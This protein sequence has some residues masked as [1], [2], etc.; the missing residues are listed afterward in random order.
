MR[1]RCDVTLRLARENPPNSYRYERLENIRSGVARIPD[2]AEVGYE[3]GRES[4]VIQPRKVSAGSRSRMARVEDFIRQFFEEVVNNH[5]G[6]IN[7]EIVEGDI[8]VDY[9]L[10]LGENNREASVDASIASQ[11]IVEIRELLKNNDNPVLT[12]ALGSDVEFSARYKKGHRWSG[13]KTLTEFL[14]AVFEEVKEEDLVVEGGWVWNRKVHRKPK[15]THIPAQPWAE[16]LDGIVLKAMRTA[17]LPRVDRRSWDIVLEAF[18]EYGTAFTAE[19]YNLTQCTSWVRDRLAEQGVHVG[20]QI[21][22]DTFH[23]TKNGAGGYEK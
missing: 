8:D 20:R 9:G 13:Y 10:I 19:E 21:L 15:P 2:V 4:F 14:V 3:L 23:A 1:N 6:E 17:Y 12:A 16:D 7:R 22:S 18:A 11:I 5:F